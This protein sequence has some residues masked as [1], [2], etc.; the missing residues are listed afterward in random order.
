MFV[1]FLFNGMSTC[2]STYLYVYSL[3]LVCWSCNQFDSWLVGW[4]VGHG[5]AAWSVDAYIASQ[6]VG[7]VSRY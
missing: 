5:T 7:K 6:S 2:L 4:V 1:Y 3:R